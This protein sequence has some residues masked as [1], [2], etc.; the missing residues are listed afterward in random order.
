MQPGTIPRAT[1]INGKTLRTSLKT[2][3]D[4]PT[5]I[6]K[7]NEYSQEGVRHPFRSDVGN[8]VG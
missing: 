6:Q 1:E 5:L 2:G 8:T 4:L 3:S 7:N